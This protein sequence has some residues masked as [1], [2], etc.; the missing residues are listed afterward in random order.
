MLQISLCS[1][2]S[3]HAA[4]YTLRIETMILQTEFSGASQELSCNLHL[5]LV[6]IKEC[7]GSDSLDQFLRLV[8]HLGNFINTVSE[9]DP[10]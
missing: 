8:L 2:I 1:K 6:A 5:Y 9:C 3:L 10:L 4:D 7:M